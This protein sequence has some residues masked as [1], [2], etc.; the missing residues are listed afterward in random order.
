MAFS[1][2]KNNG[3]YRQ[4]S[5]NEQDN[6][7]SSG[8]GY[9]S[10][11]ND[12]GGGVNGHGTTSGS[13]GRQQQLLQQQ[14]QGLEMLG[15]SADRLGQ[16]SLQISEEL[17]FQNKILNEIDDDL[18]EAYENLDIVTRKTQEFI[19]A[20]GGTKNFLIILALILVIVVLILLIVYI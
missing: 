20:S 1:S 7:G 9:H 14:D 13:M 18:D 10:N 5:L 4:V 2:G 19:Q 8:N 11:N 6:D 16:M 15:Q 3:D 12:D 17:G